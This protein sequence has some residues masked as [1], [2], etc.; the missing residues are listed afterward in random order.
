LTSSS[1]STRTEATEA[2]DPDQPKQSV[3][4]GASGV[5]LQFGAFSGEENAAHLAQTLN[6]HIGQTEG[7]Q[8]SVQTADNLHKVQIGPYPSRTAA[9]NAAIRIKQVTGLQPAIAIR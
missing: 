7:R 9:V 2:S 3:V 8:V 4:V 6:Q 1:F 5:Y